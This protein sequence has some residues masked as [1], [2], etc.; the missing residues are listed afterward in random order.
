MH[1]VELTVKLI[2]LILDS[3]EHKFPV[4]HRVVVV[5]L[6][7]SSGNFI[8]VLCTSEK[9]KVCAQIVI[10]N[11]EGMHVVFSCGFWPFKFLEQSNSFRDSVLELEVVNIDQ[12]ILEVKLVL[13]RYCLKIGVECLSKCLVENLMHARLTD[14]VRSRVDHWVVLEQLV[15]V[16]LSLLWLDSVQARCEVT[17]YPG[18]DTGL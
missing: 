7:N 17:A 18:Q 12:L 5:A 15:E 10:L 16:A 4:A 14:F 11:L 6:N 13:E 2:Q 3:Q 9:V 8:A 1:L